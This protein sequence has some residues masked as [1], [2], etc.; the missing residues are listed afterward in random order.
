MVE[1][2]ASKG[3]NVNARA[4]VRHFER[5]ITA[6]QRY[7]NTHTGGLTP[8]LYAVREN[9]GDCVAALLK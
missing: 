2:L 8:L 3:A 7:K 6:E 4:I 9:C 1:L 5:H